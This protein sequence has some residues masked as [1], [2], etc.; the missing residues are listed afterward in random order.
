M[1]SQTTRRKSTTKP[2]S[3]QLEPVTLSKPGAPHRSNI[4]NGK[5]PKAK[6]ERDRAFDERMHRH[7]HNAS[8]GS[9]SRAEIYLDG[10]YKPGM[11]DEAYKH[12]LAAKGA[13]DLLHKNI[14]RYRKELDGS[15]REIE[16][17]IPPEDNAALDRMF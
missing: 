6:A 4:L 2:R 3:S 10:L 12:F 9:L 11:T 5:K 16:H 1:T 13:L 7:R 8:L 14:Y 17:A 15:V